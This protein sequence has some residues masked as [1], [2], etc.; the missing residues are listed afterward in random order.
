[1]AVD[2]QLAYYLPEWIVN[3]SE[4]LEVDV[5]VYG[6]T[7][8]GVI[9]AVTAARRGRSVA[10]LQPG[11]H[12][13]GMTTG[14]LGWTDFGRKH[15]IGG[16]SRRFYHDLGKHYGVDEAWRFFPQHATATLQGYLDDAAVTPRF[17]QY[18]DGVQM[19]GTRLREITL[20]GG[21]QVE[22]KQFIDATYEGD[23]MA[24][25]GVAFHVGREANNR[26]GEQ[27]NGVQVFDTHNFHGPVDPYRIEGDPASGLLPG[28]IDVDLSRHLG[29][30][31]S[32]LQAYNFRVCMT[33]DPTLKVDWD[34]PA[35]FDPDEYVLLTR[36]LNSDIGTYNEPLKGEVWS[37]FDVLPPPDARRLSQDRQQQPRRGVQ[38]LHRS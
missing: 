36:W 17:A 28:I 31:D 6:A 37:K 30:G 7:A 5:C 32:R 19:D 15:V 2:S 16:A 35:G 20:L 38:R 3:S 34:R 11:R 8:A 29:E 9:A 4:R 14:G 1:M 33:D 23:L 18:L 25:A 26:Y 13:G 27:L 22:A 24:A 12:L 21:L 10:L